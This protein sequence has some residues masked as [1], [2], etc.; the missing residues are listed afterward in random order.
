MKKLFLLIS[1]LSVLSCNVE[2]QKKEKLNKADKEFLAAQPEGIYAKFETNK[3]D[4]YTVL[5]HKKTPMTVASFV[6]LAEGKIKN[7]VKGEGVPYFDGLKFHR[8]IPDFMIQGGCPNGNGTGDPGYSFADELDPNSDLA[9]TGYVRGTLAMANRG[10]NTNGSQFFLMHKNYALPYNYTIFGH[11]VKGIE[12]V[13][14]IANCPRD[15]GDLPTVDQSILHVVILRKGK[16][17]EAFDAPKVFEAEKTN[18]PAKAAAKAKAEEEARALASA[19]ALKRFENAKTTTSGLKYIMEKE[20]TGESP[21]PTDKVT[22]YYRGTFTDGKEFD[23]NIGK[24]QPMTFGLNQVIPGWVE[25]F[26]LMKP[27]GKGLFY[28]PYQIGYGVSGHPSGVI[29]PKTDL[30]F[31]LELVKVN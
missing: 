16:E 2:A 22:V 17:A 6:G 24:G 31:E 14:T 7:S 30:I 27:G 13:D 3:G 28:M 20:G 9:K 4:I 11:V 8:I 23:G 26:Q 21:K 18:A 19:A 15:K 12:L 1:A 5:E 25:A 29:P 10:A